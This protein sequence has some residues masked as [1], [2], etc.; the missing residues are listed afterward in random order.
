MP[1]RYELNRERSQ[2]KIVICFEP[3]GCAISLPGI[4]NRKDH[5]CSVSHCVNSLPPTGWRGVL[6]LTITP[7][8][9]M[10]GQVHGAEQSAVMHTG[11][12]NGEVLSVLPHYPLTSVGPQL[13][14]VET[15]SQER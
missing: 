13:A 9:E 15:A 8:R 10:T 12:Q 6:E 11:I 5:R 1:L 2:K 7:F 14:R 3:R 4:A